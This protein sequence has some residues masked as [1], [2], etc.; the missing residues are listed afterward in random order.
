MTST[1]HPAHPSLVDL[2]VG[3]TVRVAADDEVLVGAVDALRTNA[4]GAVTSHSLT[5]EERGVRPD[6]WDIEAQYDPRDGWSDLEATKRVYTDVETTFRDLGVAEI[7]AISLGID[8]AELKPGVTV[9]AANGD[10]YRVIIPPWDR[11][12]DSKA[13]TYNL[14]SASN[15]CE[16]LA[17]DEVVRRV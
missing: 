11:E 5:V 3:T 4:S 6:I 8:E 10:R 14:D 2:D 7:D 9:E 16:K 1:D 13:L 15:V 17:A 12:Y